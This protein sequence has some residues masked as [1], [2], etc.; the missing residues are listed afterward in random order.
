MRRSSV[1]IDFQGAEKKILTTGTLY[2]R[3]MSSCLNFPGAEKQ[4]LRRTF[5]MTRN[6]DFQTTSFSRSTSSMFSADSACNNFDDAEKQNHS[7]HIRNISKAICLNN[8]SFHDHLKHVFMGRISF[9]MG[10]ACFETKCSARTFEM[11]E[12]STMFDNFSIFVFFAYCRSETR[13]THIFSQTISNEYLLDF[14]V[15]WFWCARKQ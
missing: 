2:I 13:N 5:E 6:W 11:I 3:R 14:N 1:C 15:F 8:L 7:T 12:R 9:C 4:I 10:S